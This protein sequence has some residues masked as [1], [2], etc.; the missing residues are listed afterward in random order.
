MTKPQDEIIWRFLTLGK[1]IDFLDSRQLFLNRADNFEDSTEGEWFAHLSTISLEQCLAYFT[2]GQDAILRVINE[3]DKAQ[4]SSLSSLEKIIRDTLL[5]EEFACLDDS[6]DLSQLLDESFLSSMEDRIEWLTYIKEKHEEL[7]KDCTQTEADRLLQKE[8]VVK[9]KSRSYV[10]SWFG[11]NYQSMAMWKMYCQ[12][13]EGVAI[14]IQNVNCSNR[15]RL[16]QI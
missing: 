3:V 6:D 1:F 15:Y 10:S 13:N 11:G 14:T 7:V 5:D 9:L 12:G 2:M 4:P 8:R 16:T